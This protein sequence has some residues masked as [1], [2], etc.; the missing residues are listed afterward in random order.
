M[1]LGQ[2]WAAEQA[3]RA[4][5]SGLVS[6]RAFDV[7]VGLPLC[8]VAV[9]V[10]AVL[11]VVIA[12]Q[13]KANPIFV[14]D[15]VGYR[16]RVV[17]MPKLRTLRPDAPRYADKTVVDLQPPTRFAHFLRSTHLDELPQVF[18]V[19]FGQLSLV[20]P[21]PRMITEA[22]AS[23]DPD[24]EAMRTCVPQGC[25]GL[26]QISVAQGGRVSDNHAYAQM[27]VA[28]R[29]LRLDAWILWRTI[30]QTFGGRRID[31]DDIPR[32]TLRTP[33]VALA[34]AA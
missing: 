16:G 1:T 23:F 14:H 32:W 31:F 24:I 28:Q 30:V 11:A 7:L 34:E 25:T 8:V 26:W 6:K 33:D 13:L 4:I 9:P 15:R 3:R 18:L 19:P 20:G 29:T 21:R 2:P 17:R 5:P 22:A 10:V 12:M 27:Y